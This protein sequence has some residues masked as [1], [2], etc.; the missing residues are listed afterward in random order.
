MTRRMPLLIL[1][2]VHFSPAGLRSGLSVR[3][4]RRILWQHVL[5]QKNFGKELCAGWRILPFLFWNYCRYSCLCFEWYLFSLTSPPM[6]SS[7]V[8]FRV[9]LLE[10]KLPINNKRTRHVQTEFIKNELMRFMEHLLCIESLQIASNQLTLKHHCHVNVESE[11]AHNI[12]S[13]CFRWH[14]K[15]LWSNQYGVVHSV[16]SLQQTQQMQ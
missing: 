9:F 15:R 6:T 8:G 16:Q 12:L 1:P 7:R 4:G 2:V 14:F 13:L 10:L 3:W 11:I 5:W